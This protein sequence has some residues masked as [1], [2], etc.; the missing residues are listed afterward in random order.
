MKKITRKLYCKAAGIVAASLVLFTT[1]SN[2]QVQNA[3]S[4]DGTND[5][6]NAPSA[7]SLIS[8]SA[9]LSMSFWMY[10]TV[11]VT[12]ATYGGVAGFRNNSNA[13]FYVLQYSGTTVEAR[14]R[15]S[16][17]V[18]F[19]IIGTGLQLNTWQHFTLTYDGSMLRLYRNG[20]L[21][22]SVSANGSIA[23]TS[24]DFYIGHL[25]FNTTVFSFNGK[26]D[27]VSL[28]NRALTASEIGCIY[29]SY[30]DVTDAALKLYY[31]CN[32]GVAG[33]TNTSILSLTDETGTIDGTLNGFALTGTT[34]NFI[35]GNSSATTF[36]ATFCPG[37]SYTFN[38]QTYT[39]PG[40]YTDTL[41]SV[42]GCDSIVQLNLS[43]VTNSVHNVSATICPGTTYTLGSQVLDS[44]GVYDETFTTPSGCDSLVHL[45]LSVAYVNTG[46]S[47]NGTTL[48]A[49]QTFVV[50]QWV[51]CGNNYA[52]I[53]NATNISYNTQGINGSYAVI[54]TM[55]G[56]SDTSNCIAIT[57]GIDENE[58][59]SQLNIFPNPVEDLLNINLNNHYKNISLM[60]TDVTGKVML[61]NNYTDLK[62]IKA[63]VSKWA[64]GSYMMKITADNKTAM[65]K[66]LKR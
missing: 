36:N 28:W 66:L 47:K 34:S 35:T 29:N 54:I 41:T 18:N 48:V 62:S 25:L 50:Y 43:Y 2:A 49:N 37:S 33:G 42:A 3:L 5:Y 23:S 56:C 44:A 31:K 38:G 19:D 32:Q 6:V 63:D 46:V 52:I 60:I 55:N 51:N 24:E 40:V 57:T 8:G 30:A 15:N 58:F 11:A 20:V 53:P 9:G 22:G 10:P 13:D 12:S 27:E 65:L 14:F 39:Q 1:A 16:A 26:V 21:N 7:S 61:D 4:F 17:G 45:T 59:A 64:A